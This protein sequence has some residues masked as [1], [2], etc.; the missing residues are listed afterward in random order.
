MGSGN[1]IKTAAPLS[2]G[3]QTHTLQVWGG[4]AANRALKFTDSNSGETYYLEL[5]QPAGYDGYLASGPSGNRGVKITKADSASWGISSMVIPPSTKPF[6]GLYNANHAWQA[7]QTFTTHAGTSVYI[8]WVNSTSASVTIMGG[9][10]A[11]AA[12]P[13]ADLYAKYPQLGKPIGSI[14]TGVKDNGAYQDYEKGAIVWSPG[15]GARISMG[16]IRAAWA[17]TGFDGGYLGLP[18][19]DEVYGLPNGGAY[20][21]Y[22]GGSIIYSPATGARVSKNGPIR[23]EWGYTGFDRSYLGYPTSNE[24]GGLPG[25]GIYQDYQHGSII[26]SPATG[27]RVS[28]NGPIRTVWGKS[29]FD[30]SPLGYPTENEVSLPGGGIS[31]EYQRGTIIYSPATGTWIV[32]GAV[33]NV[34]R[35][36]GSYSSPLGYPKGNEVLMGN[37]GTYQDYEGGAIIWSAK[38]GAQ[39]SKNGPIRT[40]WGS[41]GFNSGYLGLP[42]GP[43]KASAGGLRQD[44]Q[45][46]SIMY[47][48]STGAHVLR[49][50]NL[51]DAYLGEGGEKGRLGFLVSEQYLLAGR[52]AQDFQGGRI[53]VGADGKPVVGAK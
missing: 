15:T 17:A 38:T 45:N 31:Q 41:T 39:I 43:E 47:S 1:D 27:A 20:Q 10:A 37:Q 23:N 22:Q 36:A 5:R 48:P 32:T 16:A 3:A 12:G 28:R 42:T 4:S 21:D 33:R 30:R 29:G 19:T 13:I 25:G 2:S 34:W 40:A 26:W 7:G 24:I 53:T 44:Y 14:R 18:I 6:P 52:P 11:R 49:A 46:G 50:G 51:L 9:A 8:N 35:A